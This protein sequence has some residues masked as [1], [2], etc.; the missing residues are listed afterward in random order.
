MSN[1]SPALHN[2]DREHEQTD[3]GSSQALDGHPGFLGNSGMTISH[4]G[5][6]T[7]PHASS[8]STALP[9]SVSHTPRH[10]SSSG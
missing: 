2:Q 3:P 9:P 5:S 4:R 1:S 10:H 6:N 8:S 7:Q